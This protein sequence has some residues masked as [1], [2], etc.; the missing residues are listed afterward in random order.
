[1]MPWLYSMLPASN[2]LLARPPSPAAVRPPALRLLLALAWLAICC[3]AAP[4]GAASYRVELTAPGFLSDLLTGNLDL[5]RYRERDDINP[6][7]INFMVSQ[8]PTNVAKLAAT[9]GYFST[10]TTVEVDHDADPPRIRLRVEA[11]PRTKVTAVDL[12]VT[13]PVATEAPARVRRLSRN[14]LLKEGEP[15][16]QETWDEAK[17]SGLQALRDRRYAAAR[18]VRSQAGIY[19]ERQAA[20]L[21]VAYDSGPAFTLGPLQIT[22]TKRYP[23][24]II[25]NV[26]P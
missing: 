9:E 17:D 5:F 8:A 12:K 7:Q 22:G 24:R 4:A 26:N 2:S 10:S 23:A 14:W 13:G 6:D 25:E 18:I 3:L 11:G 21:S 20:E 19:P 15:F 16:R 1:S